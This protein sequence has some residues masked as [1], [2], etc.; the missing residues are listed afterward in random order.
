MAENKK[1]FLLYVDQI[2][3][4]EELPDDKAG[5]L[6]KHIFR[7]V[8]DK[9]PETDDLIIKIAFEPIKRQL[10]RDLE[11]YEQIRER[12]RENA[13]KRWDAQKSVTVQKDATVCDRI[14]N[15]T[16]N[17]DKD[18][19]N[20]NDNVNDIN[21]RKQVFKTLIN[22]ILESER[23]KYRNN[24]QDIIDFF[25][26]W[27]EHGMKDKKM[28]FEKEKSFGIARRLDTWFTNKEKFNNKKTHLQKDQSDFTKQDK[29]WN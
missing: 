8:N 9:N 6:I 28:R 22:K 7:Y 27:T 14:P 19:D 1:S 10:K 18:N 20:V 3:L 26:Y 11:K 25:E 24:K 5:Q 29:G 2:G 12:N 4:F 13:R 15:N 23:I 21:K 17:A 16:K